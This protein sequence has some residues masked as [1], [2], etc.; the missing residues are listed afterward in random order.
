MLICKNGGCAYEKDICC[1]EC[2]N[3]QCDARCD[4][5][6]KTCGACEGVENAAAT[7]EEKQV[8]LFQSIVDVI[9][10]KKRLEEQEKKLKEKLKLAMEQ[11]GV[12]SFKNNKLSL[13]YV[14]ETTT[15]KIDSKQ[16]K[17]KYPNVYAE[18][19]KPSNVSAYVKITVK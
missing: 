6:N 14:A 16:V 2:D 9:E 18:C 10:N 17:E 19:S 1:Y 5:D 8:A 3:D 4:D 11:Y 7:F 12:K 13:T 15:V